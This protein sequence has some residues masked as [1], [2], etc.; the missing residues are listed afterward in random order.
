MRYLFHF[1]LKTF[2]L[3]QYYLLLATFFTKTFSYGLYYQYFYNAI[4]C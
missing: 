4:L 2:L 1:F 3:Y